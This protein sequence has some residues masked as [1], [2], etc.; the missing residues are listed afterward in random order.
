[1]SISHKHCLNQTGY[2]W[3]QRV[4]Q[5]EGYIFLMIKRI[6]SNNSNIIHYFNWKWNSL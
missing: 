1:M 4:L 6:L 3:D 5:L 2:S